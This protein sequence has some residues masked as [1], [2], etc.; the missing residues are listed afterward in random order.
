MKAVCYVDKN[1]P[2]SSRIA[3][4][5]HSGFERHGIVSTIRSLSKFNG[6]EPDSIAVAY[7]WARPDIFEAYRAAGQH[8]IHI[9]LGWWNRKP[10]GD[11][12]NGY[13]KVAVDGRDPEAYITATHAAA[14]IWRAKALGLKIM[15]WRRGNDADHILVA[16]M[17][18]KSAG[19]YG[20]KPEEWERGMIARLALGAR[21]I[22]YR[23]KP[24]W[25][26]ARPI[27]GA[28]YSNAEDL[29]AALKNCWAVVTHHSNVAIDALLAGIPIHVEYP[30]VARHFSTPLDEIES[31]PRRISLAARLELANALSWAQWTPYEMESGRCWSHLRWATPA[32]CA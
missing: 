21:P 15:E 32:S 26:D 19:T 24:S 4:A 3:Q 18:E 31:N 12:L 28:G 25:P 8:Y 5:M 11:V 14:P 10:E 20:L 1:S 6:P 27:P 22:V 9:D 13:H 17:S 16:G 30:C 23:P 2:R 29:E 7:G